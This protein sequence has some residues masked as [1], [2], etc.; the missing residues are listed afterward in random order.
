MYWSLDQAAG[1][2]PDPHF[3]WV[4]AK[5]QDPDCKA[6]HAKLYA[7]HTT[8]LAA[9]AAFRL[10]STKPFGPHPGQIFWQLDSEK[11]PAELVPS[12]CSAR[13]QSGLYRRLGYCHWC[14]LEIVS[15]LPLPGERRNSTHCVCHIR[16]CAGAHG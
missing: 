16:V 7:D 6:D 8:V 1:P 9:E 4:E 11:F 12:L 3:N 5:C 14:T 15:P 10:D 2:T 13:G